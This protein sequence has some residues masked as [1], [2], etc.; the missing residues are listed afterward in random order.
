[1]R[2]SAWSQNSGDYT[3]G[4]RLVRRAARSMLPNFAADA[5]DKGAGR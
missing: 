4:E 5:C 3:A 1:M 2:G